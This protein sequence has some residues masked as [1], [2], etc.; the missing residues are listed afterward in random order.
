MVTR[1][2]TQHRAFIEIENIVKKKG[3][4]LNSY[5][6]LN[7]ASND[8]KFEGWQPA[9]KEKISKLESEVQDRLDSIQKIIIN[10]E[11][12][13]EKDSGFI[14]ANFVL[15]HLVLLGMAYAGYNGAKDYFYSDSKCTG[16]GTCE[17]VCLSGKIKMVDN[18]PAWQENIKSYLCYACLNY[19]PMQA[20]QIKSKICTKSYTEENERYSHPYAAAKDIAAQKQ[21]RN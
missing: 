8:P 19:C 18:K 9:T 12:S 4:S 21:T 7:M 13:R 20:V 11:N 14:S 2:G 16:C 17:K 5:F 1:A 10:Q 15:E 6:T 3:K